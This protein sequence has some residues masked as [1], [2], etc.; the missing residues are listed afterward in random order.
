M[1]MKQEFKVTLNSSKKFYAC[2]TGSLVKTK[3]TSLG[4]VLAD[5]QVMCLL[6]THEDRAQCHP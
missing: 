6:C 4:D 1:Q 3:R 5:K 2:A